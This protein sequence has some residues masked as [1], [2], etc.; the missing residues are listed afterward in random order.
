MQGQVLRMR[1]WKH[2]S[3]SRWPWA[4]AADPSQPL[5]IE[6]SLFGQSTSCFWPMS[7]WLFGRFLSSRFPKIVFLPPSLLTF[8]FWLPFLLFHC[9]SLSLSLF[10][11]FLWSHVTEASLECVQGWVELQIQEDPWRSLSL[12]WAEITNMGHHIQC[13]QYWVLNQ[14]LSGLNYI[15]K[16]ELSEILCCDMKF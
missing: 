8:H 13:V 10:I 16:P 12:P 14:V 3:E 5:F 2:S 9:F 7:L 15:L 6:H 4:Y 11:F 1:S